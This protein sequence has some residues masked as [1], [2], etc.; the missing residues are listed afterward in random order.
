MEIKIGT[1]EQTLKKV[2]DIM[3]EKYDLD[4]S[5]RKFI[6]TKLDSSYLYVDYPY[7]I[8]SNN[9]YEFDYQFIYVL[10]YQNGAPRV[11]EI[12]LERFEEF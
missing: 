6:K 8:V 2:I 5:A 3:R 12:N 1:L 9:R 10:E 11:W 4:L 7:V